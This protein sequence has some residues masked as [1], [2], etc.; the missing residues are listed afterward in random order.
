MRHEFSARFGPAFCGV[1]ALLLSTCNGP[2]PLDYTEAHP[3]SAVPQV[4]RAPASY[5]GGQDP[6]AGAA[7]SQRLAAVVSGYLELGHGPLTITASIPS[8]AASALAETRIA[9][10]RQRVIAAGVPAASIGTATVTGG[11]PDTITLSYEQ[12]VAV[13]PS[14]GDFS[15]SLSFNP[16]NRL[17]P[18]FGCAE[19]RNLG[20]MVADPADLVRA[21]A[22]LPTDTS[23]A[24]RVI[25]AYHSGQAPNVTQG[26]LEQSA[27]QNAAS[28]SSVGAAGSS[29]R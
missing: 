20:E 21:V 13:V 22:P 26:S 9:A 18:N 1:A 10:L 24:M 28:G 14:C 3:V 17:Y 12:F 6:F 11:E 8:P 19:Q 5:A 27:D 25:S 4:V 2:A 23:N 29:T 15:T 16:D 7:G